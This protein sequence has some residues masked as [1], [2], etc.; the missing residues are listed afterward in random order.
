MRSLLLFCVCCCPGLLNFKPGCDLLALTELYFMYKD[1]GELLVLCQA[2][3]TQVEM[4]G[5][6]ELSAWLR[7]QVFV[8]FSYYFPVNLW[9][10][11]S[12]KWTVCVQYRGVLY[13]TDVWMWFSSIDVLGR[14]NLNVGL[15][16]IIIFIILSMHFLIDCIKKCTHC[17]LS[18][19]KMCI[20]HPCY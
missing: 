16:L 6:A 1:F 15:Q 14:H 19:L 9:G 5:I 4:N 20:P 18:R 12:C 3:G 10:C 13:W 17:F 11:R 7:L 2:A 8:W